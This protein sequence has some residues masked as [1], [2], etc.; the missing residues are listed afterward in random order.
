MDAIHCSEEFISQKSCNTDVKMCGC[1][2]AGGDEV[3][4]GRKMKMQEG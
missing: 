3:E 1:R 2:A 4:D